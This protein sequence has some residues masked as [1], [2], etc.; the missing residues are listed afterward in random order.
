MPLRDCDF[1][2]VTAIKVADAYPTIVG[3]R[4]VQITRDPLA[5][6]QSPHKG[7]SIATVTVG[8]FRAVDA[9]EAHGGTS[10]YDCVNVTDFG[11]A[12]LNLA[13]LCTGC[14][15]QA[16]QESDAKSGEHNLLHTPKKVG[17]IPGI[18]N[19]IIWQIAKPPDYHF[20]RSLPLR[21]VAG[22]N[23]TVFGDYAAQLFSSHRL[24]KPRGPLS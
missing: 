18:K 5:F 22:L 24:K 2:D 21:Q 19:M 16:N 11:H 23:P 7:L 14:W 6:H 3:A 15:D 20:I 8:G 10:H 13:S 4:T 1:S 12:A 9:V 17:T